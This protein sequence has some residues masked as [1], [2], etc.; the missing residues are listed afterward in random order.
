MSSTS[1]IG[2][3]MPRRHGRVGTSSR[4][5]PP[6]I[7]STGRNIRTPCRSRTGGRRWGRG[8]R[9]STA[10]SCTSPTASTRAVAR[11]IRAIRWARR[12]PSRR[13]ASTSRSR[14][15]SSTK[16]RTPR[17]TTAR[18]ARSALWRATTACVDF[19]RAGIW[20]TGR[21]MTTRCRRTATA[22]VRSSG[23]VTTTSSRGSTSSRTVR[24]VSRAPTW[25]G[26][27]MGWRPTRACPSRW[28]RRS[29]AT[30][31]SWPGG[32]AI[33]TAGAA[34]SSSAS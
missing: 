33:G 23:M 15:E 21:C 22:P 9:S 24:P 10:A 14:G 32:S 30:A 20:T 16:R 18:T 7:S 26:R 6:P 13:T 8:R 25:T 2:A 17:S 11:R 3:T 5:S 27:K 19:G 12:T 31:A 34:G 29:R 1:T 4:T 28:S